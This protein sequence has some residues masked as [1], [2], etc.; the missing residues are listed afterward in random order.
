MQSP[1]LF[2]S[3]FRQI[4]VFFV[5]AFLVGMSTFRLELTNP[6]RN[7]WV[8]LDNYGRMVTDP[9]FWQTVRITAIYTVSTVL[10][11]VG[12]GLGLGIAGLILLLLLLGLVA[13]DRLAQRR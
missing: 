7:A 13:L 3:S 8:G 11:Q 12:L 5:L 10:L 4:R 1:H 2:G 9:R 6:L